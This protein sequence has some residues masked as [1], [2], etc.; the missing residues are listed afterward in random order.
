MNVACAAVLS[1]AGIIF[2]CAPGFAHDWYPVECCSQRDC[3]PARAIDVDGYGWMTVTVGDTWIEIPAGFTVRLSPDSRIHV[4]FRTHTGEL[5]GRP[6]T[7]PIC[8]FLPAL[9]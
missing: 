8:L 4:C 5:D 3:M 1:L 9:S 6:I 2:G 7:M